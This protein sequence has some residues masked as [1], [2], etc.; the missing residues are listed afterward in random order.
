MLVI[1][2]AHLFLITTQERQSGD[3]DTSPKGHIAWAASL[4]GTVLYLP[5]P[6][7]LSSQPQEHC[8]TNVC[9]LDSSSLSLAFA[10]GKYAY[11]G[12]PQPGAV[13]SLL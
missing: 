13:K 7:L 1:S 11:C 8:Q 2:V 6:R 3:N 5:P 10:P 12:W 9:A 4:I